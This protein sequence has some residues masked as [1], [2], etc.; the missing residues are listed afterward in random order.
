MLA[1]NPD[2][3]AF[4]IER[5]SDWESEGRVNGVMHIYINGKS[6]PKKL[7]TTMLNEDIAHL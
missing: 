7:H 6:Y 3:F 5:V 4:L 2:K 1:G